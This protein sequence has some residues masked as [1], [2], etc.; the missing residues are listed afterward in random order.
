MNQLFY[1]L[2]DLCEEHQTGMNRC[3]YKDKHIQTLFLKIR[4]IK[5]IWRAIKSY[6]KVRIRLT[7]E[8]R[9]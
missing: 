1:F 2:S 9:H 5:D 6:L 7:N 4:N 3:F 8:W